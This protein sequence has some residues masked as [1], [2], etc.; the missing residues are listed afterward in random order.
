MC[1]GTFSSQSQELGNTNGSKDVTKLDTSN[2]M[3]VDSND[4]VNK[5]TISSQEA[6]STQDLLEICS[7]KFTGIT[8]DTIKDQISE[9]KEDDSVAKN[10][11]Q[12]NLT[13]I[14]INDEIKSIDAED[15][16]ISELLNEEEMENFKRKFDLPTDIPSSAPFCRVIYDSSDEEN[17]LPQQK[18]KKQKNFV[19]SDDEYSDTDEIGVTQDER[20][21]LC[22]EVDNVSDV[23]ET[24]VVDYDSEEN[25]INCVTESK[26]LFILQSKTMCYLFYIQINPR[27]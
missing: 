19:F 24:R 14:L 5:D 22:D 26:Y 6:P 20:I 15:K 1:S 13:Q 8:Q 16:L 25:E 11:D 9:N 17:N 3:L 2:T 12:P 21:E 4:I 7:G 18:K 23:E 27:K 10:E